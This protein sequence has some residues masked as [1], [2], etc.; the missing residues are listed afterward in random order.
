MWMMLSGWEVVVVRE[1][2]LQV[3]VVVD[4]QLP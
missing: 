3:V 1:V 4:T 2:Q